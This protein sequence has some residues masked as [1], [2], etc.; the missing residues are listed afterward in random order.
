MCYQ[1][2]QIK[3]PKFGEP[4]QEQYLLVNC[5][6]CLE[7][8]QK[9]ANEWAVRCMAEAKKFDHNCFITLTYEK[10]PILLVKRDLQL[11]FKRL[12]KAIAPVKI[13]FF[14]VGEYGSQHH[15]PHYH[16]IIFGY[17]FPDKYLW[18]KSKRGHTIY[19]SSTLEKV[20]TFGNS[21]IQS[22]TYDSCAYC[23]LY[24][25]PQKYEM[26]VYLRSVPEFNLMSKNLGTD[27]LL[28][29]MPKYLQTDE[30]WY[31]GHKINIPQYILNK[32]FGDGIKRDYNPIYCDLKRTRSDK[33]KKSLDWRKNYTE[34]ELWETPLADRKYLK[35]NAKKWLTR[36][37]L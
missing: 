28:D 13:K 22:V 6:Q 10:S 8:R 14:A 7:C 36:S 32:Y 24:S 5:R 33:Y 2:I 31:N 9:R 34:K 37:N 23:A 26:P 4:G 18:S 1:P 15:R 19:R 12:R 17:D 25:S 3:N 29:N 35:E 27:F 11:F 21:T 30:I 16:A 20:W